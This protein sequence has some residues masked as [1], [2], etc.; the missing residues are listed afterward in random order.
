MWCRPVPSSVSPMYIPGRLRTA[1]RPFKTL[2]LLGVV[3]VGA[4]H[5]NSR[6]EG[7]R[8]IADAVT[9]RVPRGTSAVRQ[10][11]WIAIPAVRGAVTKSWLEAS[12]TSASS[13]SRFAP[14]SSAA[15]SS[16][17]S[18]ATRT[19]R[20]R[21]SRS[22]LPEQQRGRRQLLL[23]A[24]HPVASSVAGD[25]H[26][27]IRAMGSGVCHAAFRSRAAECVQRLGQGRA[28]RASRGA[29]STID[30][31]VPA[32][33][34]R[35]RHVAEPRGARRTRW[36]NRSISS[37]ASTS[38]RVPSANYGR[39]LGPRRS[40]A[41]RCRSDSLVASPVLRRSLVPRGTL[42]SPGTGAARWARLRRAG[43]LPDRSPAPAAR[44][45]LRQAR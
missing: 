38:S 33:A 3:D 20:S 17:S 21:R 16:T 24:G 14:S 4:A 34:R 28:R 9:V 10:R 42:P 22:Q 29:D 19:P 26:R 8:I 36:R 41:F 11:A 1:S 32:A 40:A 25:P 7:R 44:R 30:L 23:P 27:Q 15:G 2:I 18:A 5:G 35:P 31:G 45:Q 43:G 12:R 6:F 37:P 39:C 13:R